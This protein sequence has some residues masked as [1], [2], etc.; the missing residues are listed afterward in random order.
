MKNT[1]PPYKVECSRKDKAVFVATAEPLIA[2]AVHTVRIAVMTKL[3]GFAG[4]A[5]DNAR[6]IVKCCNAWSDPQALRDRLAE[7]E[8][9]R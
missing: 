3:K 9:V 4:N 1:P 8:N 2:G 7:L 5:K 6:F